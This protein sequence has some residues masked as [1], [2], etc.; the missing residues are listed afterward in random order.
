MNVKTVAD[1][2]S[3]KL[4][5]LDLSNSDIPRIDFLQKIVRRLIN[6]SGCDT[7]E[8]W[9]R[10]ENRFFQY[11]FSQKNK[12]S[13]KHNVT[14]LSENEDGVRIPILKDNTVISRIRLDVIQGVFDPSLPVFTDTG[15]FWTGDMKQLLVVLERSKIHEFYSGFTFDE[16]IRSLA[17]LPLIVSEE[18]F[19]VLQL[20]SRHHNYFEETEIELYERISTTLG[21]S[22]VTQSTQ[23]ALRERVKELTCLYKIAQLSE[24]KYMPRK[25]LLK[26]IVKYLPPAWQYPE[27]AF[28]RIIFDG[29]VYYSPG[30]Q[31]GGEKQI[32]DIVVNGKTRGFI[33]V[34]YSEVKPEI[35][36]GPFIKEERTLINTVAKQIA[37]I[38]E[39]REAE[40]DSLRLQEQLRHADR[41]ATIGQLVAGVAHELN[42]P[43]SNILGFAQLIQKSSNLSSQISHDIDEI[44]KASIYAREV[45]QKLVLFAR[46]IPPKKTRI[47]FNQIVD[48]ALSLL[49]PRCKKAAIKINR[50]LSSDIPE[51]TAD[52]VQLNQVLVNLV[53]N[54]IQA[55]SDGGSLTIETKM[56]KD[57]VCLIVEDTGM[58]ISGENLNKIFIPFFTTKDINEGTGLGLSVVHGIVSSH[59][60]TIKVKSKVGVGTKFIIHF[61][62]SMQENKEINHSGN[63]IT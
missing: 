63:T 14:Q 38:V 46:Q 35:D 41:L 3:L 45:I 61:P 33:E 36:E 13:F 18:N 5:I 37:L 26:Q 7:V 23:A 27:I 50:T 19:G 49:A 52:A 2:R 47:K 1:F 48:D 20:A 39:Q 25:E 29:E 43:L 22:I 58:G 60:G 34:K 8:L 17:L 12:N 24:Q 4:Y 40:I 62:I 51:I 28:S 54:S 30:F 53:V 15:S 44:V 11:Y 32:S 31:E 9:L 6:F 10:E 42:E 59:K 57:H 56:N 21:T 55:M 16:N